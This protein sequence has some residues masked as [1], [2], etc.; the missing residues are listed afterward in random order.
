MRSQLTPA[1][2]AASTS[3]SRWWSAST[4]APCT[5]SMSASRAS[6]SLLVLLATAPPVQ[7]LRDGGEDDGL[8][9]TD[10]RGQRVAQHA[11][12]GCLKAVEAGDQDEE[13]GQERPSLHGCS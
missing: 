4:V 5:T 11:V 3:S 12:E 7:P 6:W 2:W 8:R 9:R 13:G 10:G 1:A